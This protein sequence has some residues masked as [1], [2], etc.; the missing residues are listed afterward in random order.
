M[1]QFIIDILLHDVC[2]WIG[3]KFMTIISLGRINLDSG[4]G[5]SE[6]ILA[7]WIGLLVLVGLI[8]L[9]AVLWTRLS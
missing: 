8:V 7:E 3:S 9:A 6:S 5:S 1:L 4:D 2:G